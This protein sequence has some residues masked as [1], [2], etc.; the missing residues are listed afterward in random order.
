M[1]TGISLTIADLRDLRFSVAII[2][3]TFKHTNVSTWKTGMRCNVEF[4]V[5]AIFVA[6]QMDIRR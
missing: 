6:R 3:H 4:N 1:L 2:P 5:L